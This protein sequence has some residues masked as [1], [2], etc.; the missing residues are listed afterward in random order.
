MVTFADGLTT[1]ADPTSLF[2][3]C[4][5]SAPSFS[6]A[7][8]A[9]V[10]ADTSDR[11]RLPDSSCAYIDPDGHCRPKAPPSSL[12][13]GGH[14]PSVSDW[15]RAAVD[16]EAN[17]GKAAEGMHAGIPKLKVPGVAM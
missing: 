5:K 4:K 11:Y 2:C 15:Y 8:K 9:K 1:S 7:W 13:Q 17:N 14:G 6:S 16:G 10:I 12:P 3:G